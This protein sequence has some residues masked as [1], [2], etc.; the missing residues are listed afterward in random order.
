MSVE[1]V[2]PSCSTPKT[3]RFQLN[4]NLKS[5][6]LGFVNEK[7]SNSYEAL[8]CHIRD[9]GQEIRDDDLTQLLREARGCISI[10]DANFRLF[11]QL[12]LILQWAHRS[13]EVVQEYQGFLQDLCSAHNYYTKIVIDHLVSNFKADC[14]DWSDDCPGETSKQCYQNLHNAIRSIRTGIPMSKDLLLSSIKNNYPYLKRP[15]IEQ[16]NY[17]FNLLQVTHYEPSM[18]HD[19][20]KIVIDKL[21]TLDV[22]CPRNELENEKEESAMEVDGDIVFPMEESSKDPKRQISESL[23]ISLILMYKYLWSESYD[24]EGQ[25]I[26]EQAKPLFHDL[27]KIFDE[28]ILFTHA[29]NHVQF[30]IFYFLSFKPAL[31]QLFIQMLWKKVSNVNI[32]PVIRQAAVCYM[33][34]FMARATYLPLIVVKD[35]MTEMSKWIQSYIDNEDGSKRCDLQDK[36][37]H[38][39]FYTTCQ[40]LFY[41]IAFRHKDLV[42]NKG[43][44][45]LQSLGLSKIVTCRL[46]PLR[47]CL[48]VVASNFAAVVRS[49]QLAYC[50]SIMER[51][52]R[53]TLPTVYQDASGPISGVSHTHLDA[54]FPFDP[55]LLKR[56]KLFVDP[57]YREYS[58]PVEEKVP[59]ETCKDEDD[60]DF[61]D[62]TPITPDASSTLN[63][64]SYSTSPGFLQI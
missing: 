4:Y 10:L 5:L 43:L 35:T 21:I 29:T 39:V 40:A 16:R 18:R 37:I 2:P 53:S 42:Q 14:S 63:M 38:G 58:G 44:M 64:F 20:L 23:D 3:V 55:Y 9:L 22:H 32:P 13:E 17:V 8:L 41:V 27:I 34:S 50:Y 6:L 28:V 1:A 48:P 19:I 59:K 30:L 25:V 24:S 12:V 15:T 11:V 56:S 45:H 62:S 61:L 36:R 7:D 33:A 51:N 60:D 54:F 49:Y 31:G 47:V 26:W 46:N 57:I 52:A